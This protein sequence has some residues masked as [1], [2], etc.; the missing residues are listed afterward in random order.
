MGKTR[1]SAYIHTDCG[2]IRN[3]VDV[4]ASGD[5]PHVEGRFPQKRMGRNVEVKFLKFINSLNGLVDGVITLL[6]HGTVGRDT[7]R[8]NLQPKA[9]FVTYQRI[10]GGRFADHQGTAWSE[11]LAEAGKVGCPLAAGFFAGCKDKCNPG[12]F[13]ENFWQP[14]SGAD[15][16][17]NAGLHI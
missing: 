7:R 11:Y 3:G 16:R 12:L 17:C 14:E 1:D 13:L 4:Q 5:R 15:H 6:R 9:A 2:A 10:V 8:F